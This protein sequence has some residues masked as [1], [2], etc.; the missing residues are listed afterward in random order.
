MNKL[1][2]LLHIN[3]FAA[4]W[5]VLTTVVVYLAGSLPIKILSAL[6]LDKYLMLGY[7]LIPVAIFLCL[8]II[9]RWHKTLSPTT[10]EAHKF[11]RFTIGHGAILIGHVLVVIPLVYSAWALMYN[12]KGGHITASALYSATGLIAAL[13]LYLFGIVCL[14]TIRRRIARQPVSG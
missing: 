1:T 8:L 7:L 6:K 4:L 11:K 14:E 9:W 12:G 13:P 10:Q 5:I 2:T 3:Y